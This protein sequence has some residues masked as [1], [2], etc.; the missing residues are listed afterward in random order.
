MATQ[1]DQSDLR[2]GDVG[3]GDAAG[4]DGDRGV[5]GGPSGPP[6]P[7]PPQARIGELL[8][9]VRRPLLIAAVLQAIGS[10]AGVVPFIM[11]VE[12]VRS[13][14][15]LLSG[16]PAE[17][18]RAWW[19]VGIAGMALLVRLATTWAAGMIT[20]VADGELAHSLRLALVDRL[21]RLPLGWFSATASGRV[22]RAV[23]DDVQSL[24]HLVAH[25][26][27]DAVSA[28]VA[29]VLALVY[30]FVVDWRL[31]LLC[32]LPLVLTVL[33]YSAAMRGAMPKY[34]QY[35]RSLAELGAATVEF[36]DGIAVVRTFNR[37]GNAHERFRQSAARFGDFFDGW[38]RESTRKSSWM[39]LVG[40]PV[41]V[42]TVVVVPGA[43][44]VATGTVGV[45]DLLAALV[46]GLG[47]TA[48][49]MSLG[50]SF[51]TLREAM[52]AGGSIQQLLATP[53]VPEPIHPQ[54]PA[55]STVELTDVGFTYPA[56][57]TAL[58]GV[59]L[60]LAPGTIT[61]LVGPSGSGKST[62]AAL[63]A[64]FFDPDHG[65]VRLGGVDL[66][67]IE[68]TE[69]YR[70]VGFVFQNPSLLR[71]S[72][73]ENIRLGRP[74]ATDPEIELVARAAQIHD[75][76]MAE[77]LGYA[78]VLGEDVHLSGGEQQRLAIARAL[79]ADAPVLVLDEA[80]AFADPDSEAAI[81]DALSHLVAGRTVLVV[82]HRLATITQ[83]DQIVVLD[84]GTVR[85][86][87]THAE[88]LAARGRYHRLW[89]AQLDGGRAATPV[90]PSNAKAGAAGPSEAGSAESGG[91]R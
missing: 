64:R 24:H 75:R 27:L 10:A 53:V 51:Q 80:T 40:S 61:A 38:V 85:E 76:I 84:H 79:L 19:S 88:L 13:L 81:Q 15:P 78:A 87:G 54:A 72:L 11:I 35:E 46:L 60:C 83:V 23:Q 62:L 48:P 86:R 59:D 63:V 67:S 42:L 89:Q 47:L 29:P 52:L 1:I 70:K 43:A 3:R 50:F 56:G 33:L 20:H 34:A 91:T 49:L 16:Q 25:A 66:R 26:L 69:L 8:A 22:R 73:A 57:A 7:T 28:V 77:P 12:T 37:T 30:L 31:A 18:A 55:G 65:A 14:L 90:A 82:A 39:E 32:L 6:S 2:H 4:P 74:D 68:P 58:S 41:V 45:L 71:L 9:P 36:V 5:P 21:A 44:L 17:G